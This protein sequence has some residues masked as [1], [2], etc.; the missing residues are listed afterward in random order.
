MDAN[1]VKIICMVVL[2]F[3][4]LVFGW[5]PYFLV[6]V[7]GEQSE[8]FNRIRKRVISY[9]T[10]FSGGVFLGACLL[11]LLPEGSEKVEEYLQKTESNVHYPLFEVMIAAGFFLIAL[12]EQLAHKLLHAS[13]HAHSHRPEVSCTSSER[14]LHDEASSS[15]RDSIPNIR[16]DTLPTFSG[17]GIR[18]EEQKGVAELSGS[19]TIPIN[20]EYVPTHRNTRN[21]NVPV[22]H[23]RG[24]VA[25]NDNALSSTELEQ[26]HESEM[27]RALVTSESNPFRAILLLVAL[28]F[29]TIFDGLA[30]GLTSSVSSVWQMFG[31]ICIHKSLV[32]LCLGTELF[33]VLKNKPL[34]AFLILF[35]FA[36]I[37]PLGI[38]LGMLLTSSNVNDDARTLTN[39]LLEGAATGTFLYV[40]FFEILREELV[41]K[42]GL[43]RLFLVVIG[44]GGM[45]AAKVMD[46]D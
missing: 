34:R 8:K 17:Q 28:S 39:G 33:L 40:T 11:H 27:V 7:S 44:F 13:G 21:R 1:S 30:I 9:L 20:M 29:H 12:I 42:G 37:A 4:T 18:A 36:F 38:G 45:A 3:D 22:E 14:S 31:A 25:I 26:T 6:R 35:F 19:G 32:A 41:D 23:K 46:A 16:S 2:F 10:C 5:P 24:N 15:V 43:L